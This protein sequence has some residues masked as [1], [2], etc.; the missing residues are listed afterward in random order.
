MKAVLIALVAIFAIPLLT[1]GS[2][3][4]RAGKVVIV[5]NAGAASFETSE[6]IEV[7]GYREKTDTRTVQPGDTAWLFFYPHLKGRVRIRC[8]DADGLALISPGPNDTAR[9][10]FTDVTLDGCRRIVARRG[11]AL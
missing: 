3:Y 10:L 2:L 5:R 1:L 11:F 4:L 9:M 7:G 6:T 8:V